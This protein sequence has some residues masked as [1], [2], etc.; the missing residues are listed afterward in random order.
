MPSRLQL[1]LDGTPRRRQH[2]PRC[3]D[4]ASI[5]SAFKIR[6]KYDQ[7]WLKFYNQKAQNFD[8]DVMKLQFLR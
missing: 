5:H 1:R 6:T 8:S 4:C 3:D 7:Y 2:R